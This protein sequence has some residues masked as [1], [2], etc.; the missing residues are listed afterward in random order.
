MNACARYYQVLSAD[1]GR[2]L[3][4]V[5]SV[6]H[7]FDRPPLNTLLLWIRDGPAAVK[8]LLLLPR[9]CTV[10]WRTKAGRISLDLLLLP[11]PMPPV[12]SAASAAVVVAAAAAAAVVAT[13]AVAA[14]TVHRPSYQFD[15]QPYSKMSSVQIVVERV[16]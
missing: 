9:H 2:R 10:V 13:V 11:S 7:T 12:P 5:C 3:T 6:C 14:V 8:A 1:Y 15:K 16:P 4:E